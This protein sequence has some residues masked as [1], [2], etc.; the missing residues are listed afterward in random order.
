M[1]FS[2][3]LQPIRRA[4][5]PTPIMKF[6]SLRDLFPGTEV[7]IKRDD[8]TGCALSGN[9]VRKLGYLLADARAKGCDVLITTGGVQSNHCRATAIFGRE[10]GFDS[11]LVLFGDAEADIDGNLLLDHLV[12]ADVRILPR[13]RLVTRDQI[14]AQVADELRRTGRRP[15]VIPVGGSNAV[16]ALGYVEAA[17]EIMAQLEEMNL[18]VDC[19]AVA[20]GSGGTLAG[21]ILGTRL[22]GM[23]VRVLGISVSGRAER[24]APNVARDCRQA[25][26]MFGFDIEVADEDVWIVDEY[27]GLGY[28]LNRPEEL[29]FIEEVARRSGVILDPT[30]TGKAFYGLADLVARGALP[31]CERVLF[32]HTG[33]I[34]GLFPRR[35]EFP[36]KGGADRAS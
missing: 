20:T 24:M 33:G 18:S 17:G 12:G 28:A 15:Y 8:E 1:P 3:P 7:W 19:V 10:Q 27:V 31:D 29:D 35:A 16:G 30:Y 25:I 32:I 11:V 5:L 26:E 23:D 36:R 9:K 2:P 6:D 13:A 21:L 4:N 22:Y 14:L 34:F